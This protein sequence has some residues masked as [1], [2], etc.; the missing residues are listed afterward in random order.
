LQLRHDFR[1]LPFRFDPS[2]KDRLVI[3]R[4]PL[5]YGGFSL[6]PR[7]VIS[8]QSHSKRGRKKP[9]EPGENRS[10]YPAGRL[11]PHPG[12][13]KRPGADLRS[14]PFGDDQHFAPCRPADEEKSLL[15]YSEGD[16]PGFPDR[17]TAGRIHPLPERNEHGSDRRLPLHR[18]P[19]CPFAGSRNS[20]TGPS[21]DG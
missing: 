17:A 10:A 6:L 2:F 20:E 16:P 1:A 8:C 5:I 14:R 18:P 4:V 12:Y 11:I 9:E 19:G 3:F 13:G 21:M 15:C 7:L